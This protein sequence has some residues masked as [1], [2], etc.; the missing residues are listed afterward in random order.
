[1]AELTGFHTVHQAVRFDQR[2]QQ[3]DLVLP[4]AGTSETVTVQSTSDA[5]HRAGHA[6]Q[7]EPSANVQSLQRRA[8]GVLPVRVDV[9][10]AGT[11]H[12][13]VKPLVID[14]ETIVRFRY[15]S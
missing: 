3:V 13:F 10:R 6:S 12:R 2:A 4:V 5:V 11:S 1:M 14:E 9:P 7:M 15:R 8:A